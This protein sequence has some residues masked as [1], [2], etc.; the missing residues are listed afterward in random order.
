MLVLNRDQLGQVESQL[1]LSS[2][3]V[4]VPLLLPCRRRFQQTF[5]LGMKKSSATKRRRKNSIQPIRVV[6]VHLQR[7]K[8]KNHN[9]NTNVEPSSHFPPHTSQ[10]SH[11]NALPKETLLGKTVLVCEKRK[12]KKKKKKKKRKRTRKRIIAI[13]R[14]R[15]HNYTQCVLSPNA[16]RFPASASARP[17]PPHPPPAPPPRFC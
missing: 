2:I 8:K 9:V 14:T 15:C 17:P 7:K 12:T 13:S 3:I 5:N 11:T 1:F 6:R 16:P 10:D 4:Y